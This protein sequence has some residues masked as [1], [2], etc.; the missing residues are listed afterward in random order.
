MPCE[1]LAHG[2]VLLLGS[3]ALIRHYPLNYQFFL[4]QG[5]LMMSLLP[6]CTAIRSFME[7][8]DPTWSPNEGDS[9]LRYA[10]Q[11]QPDVSAWNCERL[12]EAFASIVGEDHLFPQ[13]QTSQHFF[14]VC[15][16]HIG[17]NARLVKCK[18]CTEYS[19]TIGPRAPQR[20]HPR[21]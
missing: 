21:G 19:T 13:T 14:H 16:E 2:H 3:T 6:R 15:H 1:V 18:C 5:V 8:Y 4:L 7:K 9:A 11:N 10:F 12:A 20:V 17:R